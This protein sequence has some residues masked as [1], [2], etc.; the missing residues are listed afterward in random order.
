MLSNSILS[1]P[2]AIP[3]DF[4][5]GYRC[6]SFSLSM[7]LRTENLSYRLETPP[8]TPSPHQQ[9][10]E[11]PRSAPAL[12][13]QYHYSQDDTPSPYQQHL[14]RARSAQDLQP[15]GH[16]PRHIP[17]I[18]RSRL[19]PWSQRLR[20]KTVTQFEELARNFAEQDTV[21]DIVNWNEYLLEQLE[22]EN[23]VDEYNV[24]SE[25]YFKPQRYV[26]NIIK[27]YPAEDFS[28]FESCLSSADWN[29]G[30]T[31]L[32]V[33]SS[34][35]LYGRRLRSKGLFVLG[36]FQRFWLILRLHMWPISPQKTDPQL[37]ELHGV[38]DGQ[39]G[40]VL[41]LRYKPIGDDSTASVLFFFP[42]G[43]RILSESRL[44]ADHHRICPPH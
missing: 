31:S 43:K 6:A 4:N 1:Y 30:N 18:K 28:D 25:E 13:P 40:G 21:E 42:L 14:E 36:T 16:Q 37:R 19:D 22:D 33:V 20:K 17:Y 27:E 9:H 5:I 2:E 24:W 34:T 39:P 41:G 15:Q 35:M 26:D 11:H 8:A 32:D 10:L 38:A 7:S 23:L 44:A 12:P 3:L 29:R